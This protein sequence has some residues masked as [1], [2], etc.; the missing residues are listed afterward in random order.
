MLSLKFKL[1]YFLSLQ[2]NQY[3]ILQLSL[4]ATATYVYLKERIRMIIL[5]Q[6]LLRN[7]SIC[8]PE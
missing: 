8:R 7:N 2:V 4:H 5:M 6:I 1:K 3:Q